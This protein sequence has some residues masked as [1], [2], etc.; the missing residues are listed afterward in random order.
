MHAREL[1]VACGWSDT[2]TYLVLPPE[3]FPEGFSVGDLEEGAELPE[4]IAF[5]DD[6]ENGARVVGPSELE[7]DPH[8]IDA[9]SQRRGGTEGVVDF[10]L[11][12][13]HDRR[14]L[15]NRS[16]VEF[17]DLAQFS[18]LAHIGDDSDQG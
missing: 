8:L 10:L 18:D 12:V 16:L 1:L 6:V 14:H 3:V 13:E 2:R 4:L 15:R 11:D 9:F 17:S 7:L 5:D